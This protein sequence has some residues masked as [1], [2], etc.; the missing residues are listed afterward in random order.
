MRVTSGLKAVRPPA[1]GSSRRSTDGV[2]PVNP[3]AWGSP[4]VL[5]RTRYLG[6]IFGPPKTGIREERCL[7]LMRCLRWHLVGADDPPES[8]IASLRYAIRDVRPPEMTAPTQC[9]EVAEY[10]QDFAA[11]GAGSVVGPPCPPGKGRAGRPPPPNAG[12]QPK[13]SGPQR[14]LGKYSAILLVYGPSVGPPGLQCLR[15]P[16]FGPRTA[17]FF[18]SAG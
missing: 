6:P 16:G 12:R 3:P 1:P 18:P 9:R 2:A 17:D 8:R 4:S 11:G 15:R 14:V 10:G 13:E 7:G 5:V